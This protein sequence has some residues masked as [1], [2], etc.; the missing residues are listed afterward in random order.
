MQVMPA[1][2][3]KHFRRISQQELFSPQTNV[4]VGVSE[5][6]WL[7]KR[8]D[9]DGELS[10]A[11]YNAGPHNVDRWLARY[12]TSNKMLFVDLIPFAETRDYVAL[13][14]RNYF[15]YLS[16]Y[17]PQGESSIDFDQ[18]ASE[19]KNRPKFVVFQE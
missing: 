7:L 13:I 5:F 18:P 3:R 8:Y 10:L 16:L 12:P 14:G 2:A 4:K 19:S 15:W 17:S 9:G 1:T 11:A 6:S